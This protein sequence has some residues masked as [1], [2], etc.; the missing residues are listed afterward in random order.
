[1]SKLTWVRAYVAIAL[2]AFVSAVPLAAFAQDCPLEGS[3]TRNDPTQNVLKNRVD[4]PATFTEMTVTEFKQQFKPNLGLPKTRAKF[5]GAQL[6]LVSPDELRGVT[7]TG[8]VLRAV[9][10]GP[11]NT[12]CHSPTR[13]D[14]HIWMYSA[15]SQNKDTRT[16]LRGKSVVVEATPSWQDN[17]PDWKAGRLEKIAADRVKV[18]VSGWVMYDPEHPDKMGKTRGTLW[19][20]HPVTGIEFWTGTEWQSL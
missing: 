18:K 12:N 14:V 1:M 16:G 9:K 10:Q 2:A 3:G 6:A 7:L 5:T 20:I 11:E 8:Y 19:E 15:T 4:P 17:H 13:T